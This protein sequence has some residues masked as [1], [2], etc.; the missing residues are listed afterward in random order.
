MYQLKSPYIEIQNVFETIE[1]AYYAG[2]HLLK[3]DNAVK[4]VSIVQDKQIINTF[5]KPGYRACT[6]AMF[7]HMDEYNGIADFFII[8]QDGHDTY[9]IKAKKF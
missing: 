9:Y 5:V 1:S 6:Y 3:K 2:Q 4:F 8:H 7:K